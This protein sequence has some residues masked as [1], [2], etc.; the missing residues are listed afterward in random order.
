[1]INRMRVTALLFVILLAA[2]TQAQTFTTLY[3]FTG[4]ADGNLPEAGVIQDSAGNLYGTTWLGGEVQDDCNCGVVYELNSSGTE[5][6]LHTFSG[7]SDGS[8]P[9]TP[10]IQDQAGN[11][12]GTTFE[13][14]SAYGN[15]FKIDT[16]GNESVLYSFRYGPNGCHPAQG[17]IVD[18]SGNLYGTTS[19]C[20]SP[21]N[22]TIFKIDS[23]GSFSVVYSFTGSDG[24]FPYF[25]HLTMG[26]NGDLYGVTA[27]G[28]AHNAGALYQLTTD[29]QFSVLHSFGGA[30]DGC[31]P[32]GT[33]TTDK[34]GNL[35]GT[36]GSCGSH[37]YGTIWKVNKKGRETILHSFAGSPSDGC[38]P[39][40]GVARDSKG[41]V[42]G[43]TS[44]C[45]ANDWGGLYELKASGKLTLLHSFSG[46]DGET[47]Y[48]E[49]LLGASGEVFGTTTTG[50]K[51][52]YGT[53]WSYTP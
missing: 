8:L 52:G 18:N 16:A 48:G 40:A 9:V 36:T 46:T 23:A 6:V 28:G 50:G 53:V 22:G 38:Y 19:G 29:G 35:Y 7:S 34:S 3:N 42:Y 51:D 47:P 43:V 33:V 20:G 13:D 24:A 11:L 26:N 15:V 44:G 37:G 17:L 10:M 21:G 2:H 27:V 39:F 41:N 5:T 32:W 31:Y 12:Y 45:G 14:G 4:G 30:S 49:V 25:G 1:M